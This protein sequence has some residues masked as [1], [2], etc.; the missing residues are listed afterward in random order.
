MCFPSQVLRVF[1]DAEYRECLYIVA[2]L[3]P[4]LTI[5]G[6]VGNNSDVNI[7]EDGPVVLVC[8]ADGYP[9][10]SYRWLDLGSN[11]A[12]N[13][14]NYTISVPGDYSLQCTASNDVTSANGRVVPHSVS[15]RYYLNGMYVCVFLRLLHN[16]CLTKLYFK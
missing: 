4:S 8:H 12:K 5:S 15:A 7:D 1:A 14:R 13:E 10:P 6:G 16:L 2:D 11:E 3:S 9:L